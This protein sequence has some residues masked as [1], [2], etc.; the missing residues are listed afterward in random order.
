[1]KIVLVVFI[2]AV[3][4]TP[5]FAAVADPA[6][7]KL[8]KK[9]A[10]RAAQLKA[11]VKLFRLDLAYHGEQDKPY[12][13]LTLSVPVVPQLALDPF[14]PVVQ[15]SEEEAVRIIDRLAVDGFLD[16]AKNETP[17]KPPAGPCYTLAVRAGAR[18]GAAPVYYEDLG[19]GAPMLQ[20]LDDIRGVL[21]GKAAGAMDLLLG[22]LAGHRKEWAREQKK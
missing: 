15:I 5:C 11:A 14:N 6:G 4:S 12:Y 2:G 22:R 7:G 1:M 21:K 13:G 3:L 10:E 19:W 8:T 20:R 17:G 18:A 16:H 9:A